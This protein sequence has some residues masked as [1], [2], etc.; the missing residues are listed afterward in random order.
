MKIFF[1]VIAL[2]ASILIAVAQRQQVSATWIPP[3]YNETVWMAFRN[4][5]LLNPSAPLPSTINWYNQSGFNTTWPDTVCA[6]SY[7]DNKDRSKYFLRNYSSA[8]EATKA[9]AFVT[10]LHPCGLCSTL[11]DLSVYMQYLDLTSRGR[12]CGLLGMIN[13]ELAVE[14]F[15]DTGFTRDC[16]IIWAR[17]SQNT[18]KD[19]LDVCMKAWLEK[20][21]NNIPVNSTTLNACLECDEVMS[22]PIFKVVAG[23]TRRDSGLRSAINRPANQVYEI[24]HYYY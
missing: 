15:Q 18:K 20:W 17:D 2:V 12:E 8:E 11:K 16:S 23:R 13:I 1:F 5:T 6:V 10:H 3:L 21:P 22:G 9:G 14:C 4:K 7:P 24:Y 19:C